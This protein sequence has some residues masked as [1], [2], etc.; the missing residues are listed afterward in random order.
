L[1]S[2]IP[3]RLPEALRLARSAVRQKPL[4]AHNQ[5]A[6]GAVALKAGKLAVAQKALA[7][8]LQLRPSDA[9]S[10]V[11]MALLLMHLEKRLRA[12]EH[13]EKALKLAPEHRGALDL[14]RRLRL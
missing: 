12:K 4:S 9:T 1:L 10:H 14:K 5:A 6:L 11:N 3:G 13:L 2:Q 7:S 8:A